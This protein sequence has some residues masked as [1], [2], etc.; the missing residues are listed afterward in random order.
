MSDA[1]E[2]LKD[3]SKLVNDTAGLALLLRHDMVRQ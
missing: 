3:L 1:T 2:I